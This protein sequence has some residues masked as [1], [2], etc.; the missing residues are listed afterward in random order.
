MDNCERENKNKYVMAYL[1]YL[2]KCN[3]FDNIEMN[4]L[5]VDHTHIDID[6][7]FGNFYII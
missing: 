6:V 3:I 4:F 1:S 5:P 7:M 2:I